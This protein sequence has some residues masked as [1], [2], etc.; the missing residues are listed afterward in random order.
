MT[1]NK[2]VTTPQNGAILGRDLN[3]VYKKK[4]KN[5]KTSIIKDAGFTSWY[6]KY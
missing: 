3:A 5:E 1:T 2:R 6:V 4:P